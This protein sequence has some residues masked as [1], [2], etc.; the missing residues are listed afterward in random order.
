MER[1]VDSQK[2]QQPKNKASVAFGNQSAFDVSEN[3]IECGSSSTS[4]GAATTT[5]IISV[6][7]N[8]RNIEIW[9]QEKYFE[10]LPCGFRFCP[11]ESELIAYLGMRMTSQILSPNQI[12]DVELYRFN[13]EQLLGIFL[14]F[15]LPH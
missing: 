14:N 10:K 11:N 7:Q 6:S 1:S 3:T 12:Q 5:T 13:P 15:L 4:S 8:N 9:K 2:K